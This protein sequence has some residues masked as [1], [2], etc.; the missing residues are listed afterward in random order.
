MLCGLSSLAPATHAAQD[1]NGLEVY[2]SPLEI[3]VSPDGARL[4]VL[5]QDSREV[6]VLDEAKYTLIKS[7]SVGRMPRGMA[8]SHSGDRLYVTNSWDDTLMVI[9]TQR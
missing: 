3:A 9:D 8:L 7:I 4:Y 1:E 2:A 6:R 5:C